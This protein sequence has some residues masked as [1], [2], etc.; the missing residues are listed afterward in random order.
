MKIT[1]TLDVTMEELDAFI[2]QMVIK[3]IKEAT[4]KTV[5][6]EKIHPGYT[7]NKE[8]TGRNGR[9]GRV[10]TV[11]KELKPG[12]Y[13]V[14]F[15]SKQGVNHLTYE[16]QPVSGDKVEVTY[17]EGFDSNGTVSKMNFGLMSFFYNHSSK[18][19]INQVLSNIEYLIHENRKTN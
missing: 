7:Y 16:Y 3:D 17:T 10:T 11:I 14:T 15:K 9:E 18:K 6:P 1:R 19:R 4:N 12:L 2:G 13:H 5:T 8:L